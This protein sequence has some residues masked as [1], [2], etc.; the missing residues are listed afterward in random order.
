MAGSFNDTT[1]TKVLEHVVG[2]TSYTM[3]STVYVALFTTA[4][5]DAGGG[6]EVTGGSYARKLTAGSDWASAVSGAGTIANAAVITFVTPTGSWG[7]ATH[8]ALMASVSGTTT[9]DYIG[10][11]DLTSSQAIGTG[12]TVSF[13][14][15]ALALSLG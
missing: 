7:T 4:V 12:N 8:F 13:A 3:P 14:I 1:E 2:K 11:S 6:T 10:W 9:A 5:N 15:G